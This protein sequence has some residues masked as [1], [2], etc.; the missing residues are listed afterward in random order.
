MII[1]K[2]TIK[3]LSKKTASDFSGGSRRIE[4][5]QFNPLSDWVVGGGGGCEEQSQPSDCN[6][7]LRCGRPSPVGFAHIR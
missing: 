2:R 1:K 6:F 5:F 7:T 3:D 4:V